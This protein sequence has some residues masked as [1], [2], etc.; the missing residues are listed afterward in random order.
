MSAKYTRPAE[1]KFPTVYYTFQAKDKGS[2]ELVNYRVQDVPEE[3]FD[4][5][6]DLLTKYYLTEET[7]CITKKLS[8]D[9]KVANE[10]K[11]LIMGILKRKLSLACFRE[12][13]D[14]L[15]GVNVM[16]VAYKDDT[17]GYAMVIDTATMSYKVS[18]AFPQIQSKPLLEIFEL[19]SYVREKSDLFNTYK[20]DKY[21][22]EYG[23]CVHP[24]YRQRGIATEILKA[25]APLMKALGLNLTSTAFT[26][27]GSQIAAE[28]ASYDL[29]CEIN[30]S[31]LQAKFPSFDFSGCT[32]KTYKQM[33]LKV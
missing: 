4:R 16:S 22:T 2:D 29:S 6:I 8:D 28:R 21:M 9:E 11:A 23:Q 3:Y 5:V 32:T 12:G 15:V 18:S 20:V 30:Y 7:L 26:V 19:V 27:I 17:T 13:S 24:D 10:M 33:S 31:D 14:D 25:R 1:L